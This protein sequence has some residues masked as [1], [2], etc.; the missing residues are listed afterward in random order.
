MEYAISTIAAK[1]MRRAMEPSAEEPEHRE[2]LVDVCPSGRETHVSLEKRND[3]SS[4]FTRGQ[5][6]VN[7]HVLIPRL[8]ANEAG[9]E[10]LLGHLEERSARPVL[11]YEEFRSGLK[12]EGMRRVSHDR[13]GDASFAL[14]D[15]G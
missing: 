2:K 5:D 13:D 11:I 15:A 1:A 3:P 12:A 14:H 8:R 7:K 6:G 10:V 4:E 9:T